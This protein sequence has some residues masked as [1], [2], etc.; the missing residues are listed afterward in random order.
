MKVNVDIEVSVSPTEKEGVY[1]CYIPSINCYFGAS[2]K[3]MIEGKTKAMIKS[4]FTP[5]V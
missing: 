1:M 5:R 3:E 4:F 2:S